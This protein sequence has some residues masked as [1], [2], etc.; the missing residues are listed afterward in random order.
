MERESA[1]MGD[2]ESTYPVPPITRIFAVRLA[3]EVLHLLLVPTLTLTDL[4]CS[5]VSTATVLSLTILMRAVRVAK[6]EKAAGPFR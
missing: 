6:E 3:G 4:S 5:F 2:R 1:M